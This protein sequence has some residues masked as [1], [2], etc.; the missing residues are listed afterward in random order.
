[1]S[2]ARGGG[3]EVEQ[4]PRTLLHKTC[5]FRS[6]PCRKFSKDENHTVGCRRPKCRS[7]ILLVRIRADYRIKTIAASRRF[8]CDGAAFRLCSQRSFRRE[9]LRRCPSMRSADDEGD[10]VDFRISCY[11]ELS[12]SR[13]WDPSLASVRSR[14][15]APLPLTDSQKQSAKLRHRH[16]STNLKKKRFITEFC[17][18]C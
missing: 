7:W 16:F 3:G 13:D 5:F 6:P 9:S 15:Q 4:S 18:C 1:M 14:T 11:T 2:F 10:D 12:N 17:N 8:P